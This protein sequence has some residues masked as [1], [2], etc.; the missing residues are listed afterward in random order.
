MPAHPSYRFGSFVLIPA[1][2]QLLREGQPA[3]RGG[4][5]IELLQALV[6]RRDRTVSKGELLDLVWP[7]D[8]VEEANLAVQVSAL[9]KVLGPNAIATVPGRGYRFTA[10]LADEPA[11]GSIKS[12]A[13]VP[14]AAGAPS[15]VSRLIGRDHELAVLSARVVEQ[16]L[17]T[18]TGPGGIGKTRVALA[19]AQVVEG[20]WPDG[21][22][23]VEAAS[24]AD[25]AQLPQ[26]VAVSLR[27]TLQGMPSAELVAAALR[28]R[29]MLLLLD[30]TEHVIPG[31]TGLVRALRDAAPGVHVMVTS[32]E[33]MRISG[34]EVFRLPP[35][36]LP[37]P[38]DAPDE[39]FGA[40]A[41]FA[42]RA[43]AVDR[44]FR[45]DP[46]NASAVAEICRQLDGLPLA[47]E[48]A[49]ARL[50]LLGVNGLRARLSERL[51]LL[52]GGPRDAP[53]RHHTLRAALE[54]SHALLTSA[55]QTVLRRL[56][57]FV[58]GFTL[59]LAQRV[60]ADPAGSALDGWAV[61][62][63]LGGL[64][65]KSFVTVDPGEPP[66]Y[67]LLET[68]RV[69]ALE[70]LAEADET[71]RCRSLH[72][73]ALADLF[74]EVD[75]SRWGDDGKLSA[76]EFTRLL[77]PEVDNA[78]AALSWAV[79][80]GDWPAAVTLAGAAGLIFMQLGLIREL[81]PT[82]HSLRAH[83]DEAPASAQVNVLWRLGTNALLQ[84]LSLEELHRIKHE[85]VARA[86]AGGFRRRLQMTLSSLG[87]TLAVRGDVDAT[88]PI[89]EELRRL[90]R[91]DDPA[92][93]RVPPMVIETVIHDQRNDLAQAFA[94][95]E[96]QRAVLRTDP[97]ETI[98][99]IQCESNLA[100][101][102]NAMGRH[103]E[104][105]EIG[106]SVLARP[107]LPRTFLH[108]PTTCAYAL[109]ALGRVGEARN[110]LNAYRSELDSGPIGVY[111]GETLAMLCLAEGR[112]ADAVRINAA[113]EEY[114][115]RTGNK[116]NAVTADMRGRLER[117]LAEAAA[118]PA[119]LDR[120]R[121]EGQALTDVAAVRL[122]LG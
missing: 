41:L 57:V 74:A 84:G 24:V 4:R 122:A 107:D 77:R 87:Y 101:F 48:L 79:E 82:L 63:A 53:R 115:S 92:L 88:A 111:S 71:A 19:V 17:L 72:S 38:D 112:V 22:G 109:A 86:R 66:R 55:E 76:S 35:L 36:E 46:T 75:E 104:A 28:S 67:R 2:R 45:L 43:R 73:R 81:L 100:L 42:E 119:D 121:R 16:P 62:E 80:S 30:N 54:W 108:A 1:Q 11:P 114:V 85:A 25:A 9:R 40:L 21:V 106:L 51:R 64:V 113:L 31:V 60:A 103:E 89:L 94:T 110:I 20:R 58:G 14:A 116:V 3:L 90:E 8:D 10:P 118:Q 95:L 117:A 61:L 29:S 70:R 99:L 23:W 69:F 44:R 49:A 15:V 105:A 5:A 78:R 102:L 83:L 26:A 59:A 52:T 98:P 13:A 68:M 33:A 27:L 65:E 6:E 7:D 93:V 47:I 96:R 12:E 39:T 37:G 120:W 50:E 56:G 18:I 32:Q 91:S 97:D 34:E